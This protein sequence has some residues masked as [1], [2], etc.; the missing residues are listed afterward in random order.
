MAKYQYKARDG[1]GAIKSGVID[2]MNKNSAISQLRDKQFIPLEIKEKTGD[3]EIFNKIKDALG[4]P[5]KDKVIFTRQLAS[6]INAGITLVEALQLIQDQTNS[7]QLKNIIAKVLEDIQGGLTFADALAKYP[8]VFSD[9][10]INIV[11]AGE[12][13]GTLDTSLENLA[14]QMQKDAAVMGKIKGA[15]T[16]PILVLIVIVGVIILMSVAVIPQ[17]S[18]LF[19]EAGAS[20][21]LPTQI[22]M[23]M[24]EVLTTPL[25][26]LALVAI[27]AVSIFLLT[28]FLKT[29]RGKEIKDTAIFKMPVFGSLQKLVIYTRLTGVL[30]ML[31]KSGVPLLKAMDII[32]DLVGNTLYTRALH[33]VAKEVEKGV[34]LSQA[35]SQ[36]PLFPNMISQMLNIGEQTG[37]I[38]NM[39]E[40]VCKL[41]E[42]DMSNL[43]GNLTTLLEPMLMVIMGGAVAF[44][45]MAVLM[46]IYN[47]VNVIQ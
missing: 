29:K 21:P 34:P 11:R 42:T 30:A 39:L 26:D 19:K 46:P 13:S 23:A 24:S 25:Y 10:F 14:E 35:I 7:R 4:V 2:A 15:M 33:K 40:K 44:I 38:D 18:D 20:L 32:A 45:V 3:I 17:L 37:S 1:Q 31:L 43:I 5:M 6:I 41:Y 36:D 16:L 8:D 27:I 22:M 12:I 9:L 47:L 28:K